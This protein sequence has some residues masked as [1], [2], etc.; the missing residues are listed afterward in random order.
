MNNEQY[1]PEEVVKEQ[2][3]NIPFVIERYEKAATKLY[4]RIDE[5]TAKLSPML[6][7][8]S[9]L[10]KNSP[11]YDGPWS[12]MAETLSR[13]TNIVDEGLLNVEDLID[14]LDL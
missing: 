1:K 12:I 5:L 9:R 2:M 6:R 13:I 7:T 8:E 10:R 3:P 4:A 11:N 14:R